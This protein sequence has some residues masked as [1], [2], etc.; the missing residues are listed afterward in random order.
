M[1][2]NKKNK[3]KSKFVALSLAAALMATAGVAGAASKTASLDGSSTYEDTTHL[4]ASN[5]SSGKIY[6]T[7]T[8]QNTQTRGYGMKSINW[9]PDSTVAS[10]NWLNPG[11]SQT[12]SFTQTKGDEYYGQIVGQTVG[13]RGSVTITVY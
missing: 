11:G 4:V 6:A 5:G 8:G 12:S 10:T 1:L 9:L 7:N 3:M 13:A 2:V